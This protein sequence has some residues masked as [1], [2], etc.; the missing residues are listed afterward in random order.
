MTK[1]I[2]IATASFAAI[3]LPA[4]AATNGTLGSTSTG[5]VEISANIQDTAPTEIQ[6]TGMEDI[7][8]GIL[9]TGSGSLE[10]QSNLTGACIYMPSGGTYDLTV[11]VPLLSDASNNQFGAYILDLSFEQNGS[12][13]TE[14][15]LVGG[16][17][18]SFGLTFPASTQSDCSDGTFMTY[19][20]TIPAGAGNGVAAG[21]Y[22]GTVQFIVTPN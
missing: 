1:N 11:D 20:G 2:L 6:I 22:T 10:V 13:F 9:S 7:D 8:F 5:S 18:G 3:L 19:R 16:D 4:S 14:A 15:Q 17:N 12:L 21:V